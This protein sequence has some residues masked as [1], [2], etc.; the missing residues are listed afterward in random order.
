M[1]TS[2]RQPLDAAKHSSVLPFPVAAAATLCSFMKLYLG[3]SPALRE[4]RL[5]ASLN[6]ICLW[7]SQRAALSDM[8]E[9]SCRWFSQA[10]C[11]LA[12]LWAAQQFCSTVFDLN[13]GSSQ[14]VLS[15]LAR[16]RDSP[17]FLRLCQGCFKASQ[18]WIDLA[19][20]GLELKV[21]RWNRW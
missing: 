19:Q 5:H 10:M 7:S 11:D 1:E 21:G 20:L 2:Q 6:R 16:C 8:A 3:L 13:F 4:D 18:Y 14:S 17:G 12:P 9:D 15:R